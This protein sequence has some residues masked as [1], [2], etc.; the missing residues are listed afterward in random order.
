MIIGNAETLNGGEIHIY[1][2]FQAYRSNGAVPDTA[3]GVITGFRK[4]QTITAG[5]GATST[6]MFGLDL[7]VAPGGHLHV[8]MPGYDASDGRVKA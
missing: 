3:G 6:D 7:L 2:C 4:V 8:T 5:T 1:E